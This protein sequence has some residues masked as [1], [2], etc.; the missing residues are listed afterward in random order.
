[1]QATL[2]APAD[3]KASLR[4]ESMAIRRGDTDGGAAQPGVLQRGQPLTVELDVAGARARLAGMVRVGGAEIAL[5][6]APLPRAPGP[7][8]TTHVGWQFT[9][10]ASARTGRQ[11][12]E[13][14]VSEGDGVSTV[15]RP[16]LV[17]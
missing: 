10:P 15:H 9:V 1:M 8:Q 11:E 3:S 16:V 2:A 7:G 14:E 13:I 6:P 5:E 17:R 12:L 4:I